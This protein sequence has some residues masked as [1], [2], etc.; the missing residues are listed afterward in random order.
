MF[1]AV[2]NLFY[3][4]M[5]VLALGVFEQ[6]V[7][8]KSSLSYPKLYSVGLHGGLFNKKEFIL[9]AIHGSMASCVIFFVPY[10]KSII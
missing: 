8:D 5:A 3:T 7:N 2:Y 9:A 10:G 4:S 6:D 1:I